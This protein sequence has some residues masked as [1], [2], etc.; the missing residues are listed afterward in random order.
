MATPERTKVFAAC[1]AEVAINKVMDGEFGFIPG[2]TVPY[3]ADALDQNTRAQIQ[4]TF[5]WGPIGEDRYIRHI[6]TDP[7]DWSGSHEPALG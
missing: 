5:I 6:G 2:L 3:P 7:K 1:P 4:R